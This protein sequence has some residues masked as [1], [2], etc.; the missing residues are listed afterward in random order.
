MVAV[1]AMVAARRKE[2]MVM[3]RPA[4]ALLPELLSLDE[5][6][7]MTGISTRNLRYAA[8]TGKVAAWKLERSWWISRESLDRYLDSIRPAAIPEKQ[9]TAR[10]PQSRV[11]EAR[12]RVAARLA[13]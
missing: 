3:P 6:A 7:E 12:A 5:V 13:A 1:V 11:A 8:R 10:I 2:V 4:T 9:A